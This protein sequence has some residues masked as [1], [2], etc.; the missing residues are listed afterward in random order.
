MSLQP[1]RLQD[2]YSAQQ[3]I[4]CSFLRLTLYFAQWR[5]FG[6]N[7]ETDIPENLKKALLK[8]GLSSD[9][10]DKIVE[11]YTKGPEPEIV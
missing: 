8:N 3:V 10:A 2:W 5:F 4:H 9:I 1:I 7:L 6:V 11:H